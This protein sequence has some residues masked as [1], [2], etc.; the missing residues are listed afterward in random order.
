MIPQ[1]VTASLATITLHG[2]PVR[3]IRVGVM[4][5]NYQLADWSLEEDLVAARIAASNYATHYRVPISKIA[6]HLLN[7]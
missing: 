2:V 4:D 6:E 1:Y 3:G 5:E 7:I